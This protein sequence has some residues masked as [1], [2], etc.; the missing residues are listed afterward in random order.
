MAIN[1]DVS[2]R[3]LQIL[4]DGMQSDDERIKQAAAVHVLR[5]VGIYGNSIEPVGDDTAE[6]IAARRAFSFSIFWASK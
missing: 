4:R 5:C 1:Q 6:A 3:D 2:R